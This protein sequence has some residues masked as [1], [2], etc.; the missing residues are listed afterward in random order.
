MRNKKTFYYEVVKSYSP[1]DYIVIAR[2]DTRNEAERCKDAILKA[3]V[4]NWEVEIFTCE[5]I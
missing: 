2:F 4:R 5:V 3:S 1:T